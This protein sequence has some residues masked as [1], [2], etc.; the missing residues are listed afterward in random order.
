MSGVFGGFLKACQPCFQFGHPRQR[1]LQ[2]LE[3]RQDQRVLLGYGE[4][5]E[6]DLG[7]HPDLESSRR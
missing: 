7:G 6:V 1:C 4:F 3:Q 5:A 2:L